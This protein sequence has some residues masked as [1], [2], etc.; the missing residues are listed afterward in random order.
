MGIMILSGQLCS[1]TSRILVQEGI[2]ERFLA[3]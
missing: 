3:R 1:A 2:Y